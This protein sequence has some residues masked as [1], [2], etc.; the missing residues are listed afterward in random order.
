MKRIEYLL[1]AMLSLALISCQEDEPVLSAIIAPTNL[2]VS[3]V[4]STDG[5]G[6]VDFTATADNAITFKYNFSDGTSSE[7]VSSG[8]VSKRFT[9]VGLNTYLVTAVAFGEG[10]L[11][12]S[13]S[14]EVEV[15]SD[16]S[17][18]QAVEFL[19]G[20]DLDDAG[21]VVAAASKI[22]YLDAATPGHL[23]VGSTFEFLP[24]QYWFPGFFAAA[25]FA[26]CTDEIT[27]FCDDEFTFALDANGQVTFVHDNK[28]QSFF[29]GAHSAAGGGP[30]SGPD[31]CLDFDTSG[32]SVVT[33]SPS[34]SNLPEG[35]SR[36]TV[37]NL[38]DG[39]FMGYFVSSSSYEILSITDNTL[40]VRTLD[41]LDS[42]LAW[43]HKFTTTM[44]GQEEET[45]VSNFTNMVWA[46]EFDVDGAPDPAIWSYDLGDGCPNL[47]GWGNNEVQ[48]Y[49]DRADNVIVEGG[50]LKITAKREDFMGSEHTSSRL[51]S[52]QNFEFTYGRAEI[53]AKL[54]GGGGT[55]SALWM[56]GSDFETNPWPAAGEI[57]IMEHVGNNLDEV[58][59]TTHDPF[60]FGGTGRS[61]ST[62]VSG[63]TDDFHVYGVEWRDDEILFFIDD[64]IFHTVSNDSSLPFNKDFFFILNIAMGGNLGGAID[65]GFTESTMEVD[66]IRVYQ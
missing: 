23:G 26:L 51:K 55:W 29:N 47:C 41:G 19:T 52:H 10:G 53:R 44:P 66:Y 34:D 59:A 36:E 61:G 6:I 60:N 48:Y 27:C 24:D 54:P 3:S 58:L 50:S 22:W 62:Q 37:F 35:E 8:N 33:L 2:V 30:G 46:E 39:G 42:N 12:T 28:G 32:T 14:L 7:A 56:L 20:G 15:E 43:Y 63:A 18:F 13:T 4:I 17:D 1:A 45:I 16:F 11:S 31:I 9:G 65:P 49:T 38:T 40:Y 21:N 5:S 64:V 57:D 25:P